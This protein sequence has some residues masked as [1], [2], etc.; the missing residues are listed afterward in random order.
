MCVYMCIYNIFINQSKNVSAIKGINSN[1]LVFKLNFFM[2]LKFVLMTS[3]CQTSCLLFQS[4]FFLDTGGYLGCCKFLLFC[5][6]VFTKTKVL[7]E[8]SCS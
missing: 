3:V 5:K 4:D 8:P 7:E 6:N 1:K 2:N